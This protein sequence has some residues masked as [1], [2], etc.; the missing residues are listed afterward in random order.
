MVAGSLPRAPVLIA[1]PP[2]TLSKG[3][4]PAAFSHFTGVVEGARAAPPRAVAAVRVAAFAPV[5]RPQLGARQHLAVEHAPL[6]ARR[7]EASGRLGRRRGLDDRYRPWGMRLECRQLLLA[8]MLLRGQVL[9]QL[10][11]AVAARHPRDR[12]R[13]ALSSSWR[14]ACRFGWIGALREDKL[15][16]V[17]VW[18][19][20]AAGLLL[21]PLLQLS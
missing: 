10:Q 8:L 12:D 4:P 7:V 6:V 5:V 20:S 18:I 11:T 13:G 21:P 14:A 15:R 3:A 16:Q 2:C 17:F 19:I 9:V 1:L